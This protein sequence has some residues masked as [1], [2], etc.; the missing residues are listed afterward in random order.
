[1]K[2]VNAIPC[3]NFDIPLNLNSYTSVLSAFAP[4]ERIPGRYSTYRNGLYHSANA[5]FV[6]INVSGTS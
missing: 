5:R 4:V 1:M 6:S 2:V 3:R